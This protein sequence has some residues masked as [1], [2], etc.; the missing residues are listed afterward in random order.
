MFLDKFKEFPKNRI[1]FILA[2]I[3]FLLVILVEIFIFIPIESAVSTY[4]I[5]DYILL[6]RKLEF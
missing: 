1:L 3:G 2:T 6:G 4:G 5:L